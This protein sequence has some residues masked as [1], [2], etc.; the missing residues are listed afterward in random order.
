M[1][2]TPFERDLNPFDIAANRPKETDPYIIGL[3]KMAHAAF[4]LAEL[5]GLEIGPLTGALS[6]AWD[7][8]YAANSPNP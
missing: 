4:E 2:N 6:D 8:F 3:D 1:S 5:C 7:E